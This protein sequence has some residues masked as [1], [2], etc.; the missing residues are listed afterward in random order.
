[1][2]CLSEFVVDGGVGIEG[3]IAEPDSQEGGGGGMDHGYLAGRDSP[4]VRAVPVF[5]VCL[6]AVSG[7]P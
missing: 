3:W 7:L 4:W 2:R 1:M 5:Q 6:S